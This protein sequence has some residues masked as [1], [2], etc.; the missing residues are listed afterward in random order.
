M[1]SISIS[2]EIRIT[3]KQLGVSMA[4]LARRTGQS[5]P[6]LCSKL[7]RESFSVSELQQIAEALGLEFHFAFRIPDRKEPNT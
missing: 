1:G 7:K 5:P 4:E 2:Q 6:N 3:C